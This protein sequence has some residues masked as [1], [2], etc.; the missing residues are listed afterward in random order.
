M[1]VRTEIEVTDCRDCPFKREYSGHG[2]C[3]AECIHPDN[4]REVY[5]NILWGCQSSFK[6]IP[7]WCPIFK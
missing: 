6:S 5:D 7:E 3:W 1:L 2:E 4:K